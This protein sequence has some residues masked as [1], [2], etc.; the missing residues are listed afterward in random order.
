[1]RAGFGLGKQLAKVEEPTPA[2]PQPQT[3]APSV[4]IGTKGIYISM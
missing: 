3:F 4:I 1:M 2:K